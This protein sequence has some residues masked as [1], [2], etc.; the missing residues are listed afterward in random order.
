[1]NNRE[2]SAERG[3]LRA[4]NPPFLQML[5]FLDYSH[6]RS[7]ISPSEQEYLI[8]YWFYLG[9]SSVPDG[10]NHQNEQ[11]VMKRQ[12]PSLLLP[13]CFTGVSPLSVTFRTFI[14]FH[15]P[16]NSSHLG[17]SN[18]WENPL[19][20]RKEGTRLFL[21]K[22]TET[23][24]IINI[25]RYRTDR[26]APRSEGILPK[27]EVS[28]R[29]ILSFSHQSRRYQRASLPPCFSQR[30]RYKRASSSPLFSPKQEV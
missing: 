16:T 27:T 25:P 12:Q 3:L 20:N 10:N 17:N 14:N 29:S 24:R 11:K 4:F 28:T 30:R 9:L 7:G 19:W 23:V 21:P 15:L 5:R 18:L 1:M 6:R 2:L 22:L 8:P 13:P 26:R